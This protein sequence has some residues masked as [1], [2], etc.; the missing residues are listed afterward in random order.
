MKYIRLKRLRRKESLRNL[1]R[2][3]N[4]DIY[5]LVMPYFV[6]D[7]KNQKQEINSMPGIFRYSIDNLVR[8]IEQIYT[9]GIQ[10]VI[11]FGVPK[12]KDKT[13]S[14][15]YKKEGIVQK[16]IRKIKKEIP[17][18]VVIADVCLCS[19]TLTGHCGIIKNKN[20]KTYEIDNDDTL[21][22]L[23]KIALSYAEAGADIVA[24]SAM[25]DGQVLSIRETLDKNGFYDVAIMSYSAKYAS[26][27]YSPFREAAGSFPK[28]GDR[29]TY[30]L[31]YHN[32][33][34]ALREIET[35]IK[36]GADIVMIKPALSYLD[37]I[38]KA[39]E[40]F[41]VP[42]AAYSVSG[43]YSMVKAASQNG[44]IDEKNV[45]LEILSSIKRAGADIIITYWA[46]DIVEWIR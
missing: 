39:K 37:V 41:N 19:Y 9:K 18:V 31:D 29:K 7:G 28:F 32:I 3:T 45:V 4:L 27:F 25:M 11:L 2:E 43:E 14:E 46:K 8:D 22:I 40:S 5:D 30:Q 13:A 20:S 1:F 33:K 23:S 26:N 16:A 42:V 36:E 44:W 34:E 12:I 15:A 24:P 21:I 6:V 10:A 38:R 17:E 35:D